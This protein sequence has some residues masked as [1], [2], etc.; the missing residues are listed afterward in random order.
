MAT[1]IKALAVVL[2]GGKSQRFHYSKALAVYRNEYFLNIILGK[3]KNLKNVKTVIVIEEDSIKEISEKINLSTYSIILQTDNNS[4]QIDSLRLAIEKNRQFDYYLVWP[5]DFPLVKKTTIEK[6]L[7]MTTGIKADIFSPYFENRKGHPFIFSRKVSKI[8]MK[9]EKNIPLYEVF[10]NT[11]IVK[12]TVDIE[13]EFIHCNINTQSKLREI[14][15][16]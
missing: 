3:L 1:S 7:Y 2:S 14:D 10:K 4:K 8:I 16:R 5:V 12:E 11:N 6:L 13:D 15:A 9:M